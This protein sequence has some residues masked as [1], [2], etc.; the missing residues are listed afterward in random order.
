M[1]RFPKLTAATFAGLLLLMPAGSSAEVSCSKKPPLKPV[2]CI[3]GKLVDPVG[4]PV[5][6]ALVRVNRDGAEV[7]TASTDVD[8]RFLFHE[9][10][11]GNYDLVAESGKT[12]VPFRLPITLA[13]PKKKCRHELVIR[14]VLHYP[15]NCGSYVMKH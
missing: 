14:M 6:S 8:G 11:P 4:D 3:C 10:K 13:K 15:D 9:L 12:F 2:H 7:A 1:T 5:S